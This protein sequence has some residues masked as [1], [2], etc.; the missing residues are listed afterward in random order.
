MNINELNI[1]T[2]KVKNCIEKIDKSLM[3]KIEIEF[4]S[5]TTIEKVFY[6]GEFC[7]RF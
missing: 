3:E 6:N 5:F 4:F 1:A 2:Q 7:W